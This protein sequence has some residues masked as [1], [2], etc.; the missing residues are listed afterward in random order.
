M[1]VT[2]ANVEA[3]LRL[4]A[5]KGIKSSSSILMISVTD[6]CNPCHRPSTGI[7]IRSCRIIDVTREAECAIYRSF[8]AQAARCRFGAVYETMID[9]LVWVCTVRRRGERE[10]VVVAFV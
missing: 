8:I 1:S 2:L 9:L 7:A 3:I 10:V 4:I 5:I 6:G